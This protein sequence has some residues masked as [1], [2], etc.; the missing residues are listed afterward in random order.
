MFETLLEQ[1]AA[2]QFLTRLATAPRQPNGILIY[3]PA[4]VGKTLL[5]RGYARLVNCSDTRKDDCRCPSCKKIRVGSHPDVRYVHPNEQGHILVDPIR[6]L[7]QALAFKTNEA[8]RKIV[9][10][11]KAEALNVQA[12][13]A[14]LKALEEPRGATTWILS[15]SQFPRVLETIRS[16]CQL[17]RC[18]FLSDAAINQLFTNLS[19]EVPP[20]AIALCAGSFLPNHLPKQFN[21]LQ[22]AWRAEPLQEPTNLDALELRQEL[23]YLAAAIIQMLQVGQCQ[24]GEITFRRISTPTLVQLFT[25]LDQAIHFLARGVRPYLVLHFAYNRIREA[26]Q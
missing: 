16:R 20:A 3:G 14:M 15:T 19:Q 7:I 10:L 18:N 4:A 6:E 24:L 1:S 17:V 5:A 25:Q 21:L 9:V 8:Q 13:N 22:C 2:V 23:T 26:N 11:E 12:A